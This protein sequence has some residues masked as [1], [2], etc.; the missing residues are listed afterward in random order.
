[1]GQIASDFYQEFR[2]VDPIELEFTAEE[3]LRLASMDV[4]EEYAG[5]M[6][7]DEELDGYIPGEVLTA[8]LQDR[9]F[10]GSLVQMRDAGE[11][12]IL[13]GVTIGITSENLMTMGL[14]EE[15]AAAGIV[16]FLES[17]E[18]VTDCIR[19]VLTGQRERVVALNVFGNG[20]FSIET[21]CPS[22]AQ[23]QEAE[24]GQLPAEEEIIYEPSTSYLF[25]DEGELVATPD[26][27]GSLDAW[28]HFVE[29]FSAVHEEATAAEEPV[30][31]GVEKA[32]SGSS[33]IVFSPEVE[34]AMEAGRPVVVIASAAAFGGLLYPGIADSAFRICSRIRENGATPAFTAI[35]KGR[36]HVGLTDDEIRYLET[37]RGSILKASARDIPILMAMGVDGVMTIAAAMQVATMA[38]FTIVCGSGIGGVQIGA[39]KTMDISTD[40]RALSRSDVM[41]VCYGAKPMLDIRLTMQYL[42]TVGVP[43]IGYKTDRV[44][45]FIEQS[46]GIRLTYRMDTP[47]ELAEVMKIKAK[48]GI[49]GGVLV[50]NPA[51][52]EFELDVTRMRHA[53]DTAIQDAEKNRVTGKTAPGF[54]MGRLHEALG[55]DGAEMLKAVLL[56]NAALAA[57]V[58]VEMER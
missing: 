42:E 31:S 11:Y 34:E 17:E 23:W 35:L 37:K 15:T 52:A 19:S 10:F 41:V 3:L 38:G 28:I 4:Q 48:I 49:S 32:D 53:M 43:V 45:D 33:H 56:S 25:S 22:E 12:V 1:M 40:L 54:M 16:R 29:L 46:S 30:K 9:A 57:K 2:H 39:E 50:V 5:W 27:Q 24:A 8:L 20:W 6:E 18:M 36:I 51:P 7:A 21:E 13:S 14:D 26:V 47:A 55:P 58:A 44:P